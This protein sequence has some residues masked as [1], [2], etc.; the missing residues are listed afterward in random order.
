MCK[1]A[2]WVYFRHGVRRCADESS[3]LAS[4][5][6]LPSSVPQ[7]YWS[8]IG[9]GTSMFSSHVGRLPI[10]LGIRMVQDIGVHRKQVY[11]KKPTVQ[12]EQWKRAF[13]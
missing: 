1:S 5:F 12:E 3:K 7:A 10:K 2:W 13:W 6:L 8:L 9:L 11:S 4:L